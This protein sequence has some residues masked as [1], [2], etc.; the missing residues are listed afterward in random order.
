[1]RKIITMTQPTEYLQDDEVDAHFELIDALLLSEKNKG[2]P[3][4]KLMIAGSFILK[5]TFQRLN[6]IA[7]SLETIARVAAEHE[8]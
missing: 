1:M 3:A 7:T 8:A 5:A 2:D 6:K 4:V